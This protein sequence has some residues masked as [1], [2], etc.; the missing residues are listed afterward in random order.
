MAHLFI[1]HHFFYTDPKLSKSFR[2]PSPEIVRRQVVALKAC[3]RP[4]TSL[5]E[6][7]TSGDL[8][9]SVTV[10]DG[11][12]SFLDVLEVFQ[13]H[14]IHICLCVCGV[15]TLHQQVL[16]A[17]KINLLR[18]E[19][20]DPELYRRLRS[21]FPAFD[22][23][24]WPLRGGVVAKDLYRYD[25]PVTR[26]LKTA[27]NYQL[28][29]EQ[30]RQFIDPLFEDVFGA[31]EAMSRELYL[32]VDDLE[33]LRSKVD[34]IGIAYH[35]TEHRLWAEL[36]DRQHAYELCPPRE[37]RH[38]FSDAYVLSIPY[39]MGGSYQPSRVV[40]DAGNA[41]GAFTMGRSLSHVQE[42]SASGF[43]WLHRF[44]QADLFDREGNLKSN[45][46]FLDILAGRR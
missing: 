10:D 35:G 23:S 45:E 15:S 16:L 27:L 39:G 21:V 28:S 19:F 24:K 30:T 37:M 7:L 8:V 22:P 32:S 44:D 29:Y 38:L 46:L 33:R 11:S 13:E 20:G 41:V 3:I 31:E 2:G 34:S 17:H 9:F 26:K 5:W 6:N 25:Q 18:N 4:A 43:Q 14:N 12:R 36:D 40:A 1:N 42:S